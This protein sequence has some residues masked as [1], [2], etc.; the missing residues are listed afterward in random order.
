MP[1]LKFYYAICSKK[2]PTRIEANAFKTQLLSN[3]RIHEEDMLRLIVDNHYRI[4]RKVYRDEIEDPL[5][6]L[7]FKWKKSLKKQT[8]KVI[9]W[10]EQGGLQ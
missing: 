4:V 9:K 8:K 1:Q 3:N 5:H 7:N 6:L 2:L 10:I